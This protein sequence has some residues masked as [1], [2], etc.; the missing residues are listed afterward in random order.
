MSRLGLP[1]HILN[2]CHNFSIS[3]RFSGWLFPYN[4]RVGLPTTTIINNGFCDFHFISEKI[5]IESLVYKYDLPQYSVPWFNFKSDWI[6]FDTK[7]RR[8]TDGKRNVQR[9]H[10]KGRPPVP[11]GNLWLGLGGGIDP[12]RLLKTSASLNF[13]SKSRNAPL[14]FLNPLSRMQIGF[15]LALLGSKIVNFRG[16]TY[17]YCKLW[18]WNP[19]VLKPWLCILLKLGHQ[20]GSSLFMLHDH[21]VTLWLHY[22]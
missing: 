21:F 2:P 4:G 9:K 12:W 20:S 18:F 17:K 22:F 7:L 1:F 3:Y 16:L 10:F 14:P 5:L 11:F 8:C 15:F 19:K 13:L 6:D